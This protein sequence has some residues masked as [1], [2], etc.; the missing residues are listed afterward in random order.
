MTGLS[1]EGAV[2]TV[3]HGGAGTTGT[4]TQI[5]LADMAANSV[6]SDQYTDA[7]IDPIHLANQTKSMYWPAGAITTDGTVCTDPSERQVNT[8]GPRQFQINCTANS[9][10]AIMYGHAVM[11]DGWDGGTVTFEFAS[12]NE[13]ATPSGDYQ[14]DVECQAAGD[15]EAV[16]A[17]YGTPVADNTL[18]YTTDG[19]IEFITS[20]DV[21]CACTTSCLGGDV[22]YWRAFGSAGSSAQHSDIYQV[23]VK[24]EYAWNPAD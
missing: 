15:G 16:D 8:T 3:L 7:S 12:I 14:W 2:T 22:L 10:S 11:P 21:T 4:W 6:D 5:V 17:T 18:T 9:S 19:D 13:N 1:N 24:M 23:G 20:A